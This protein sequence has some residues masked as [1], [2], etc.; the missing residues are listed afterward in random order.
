MV[1]Y[2]ERDIDLDSSIKSVSGEEIDKNGDESMTSREGIYGLTNRW[3]MQNIGVEKITKKKL[4]NL[5]N[6]KLNWNY[7]WGTAYIRL[8]LTTDW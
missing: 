5:I 3:E 7:K 1:E 2:I 4:L 8:I 6:N